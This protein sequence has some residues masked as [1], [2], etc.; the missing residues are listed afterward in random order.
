MLSGPEQVRLL[1]ELK[2]HFMEETQKTFNSMNRA[3]LLKNY[4]EITL[5]NLYET[6][7]HMGNLFA[8]GSSELFALDSHN[9]VSENVI[10]IVQTIKSIY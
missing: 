5:T 8:D 3:L 6:I 2:C 10:Y 7:L 1:T 4:S 9:C